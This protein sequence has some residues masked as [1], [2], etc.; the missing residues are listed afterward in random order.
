MGM[1]ELWCNANK[2]V[3]WCRRGPEIIER[4]E[5]LEAM[6]P[7]VIVP[8]TEAEDDCWFLATIGDGAAAPVESLQDGGSGPITVVTS[9]GSGANGAGRIYT[10]AWPA[11]H[12]LGEEYEVNIEV[13]DDT[14]PD[15]PTPELI[16]R[17]P[18]SLTYQMPQGDDGASED[19]NEF[20]RH[21]VKVSG[22]SENQT[23]LTGLIV[24]GVP[25]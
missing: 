7:V 4:L 15:S 8:V 23:F 12:P 13:F 21:L 1:K 14:F 22:Q 9:P 10:I 17:S 19:D 25:V 2:I 6:L 3:E 24:N 5:E 18:N 16:S 20:Y 11:S